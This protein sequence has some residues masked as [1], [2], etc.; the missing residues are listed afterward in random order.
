MQLLLRRVLV[1]SSFSKDK[2]HGEGSLLKKKGARVHPSS[3][4]ASEDV[5]SSAQA[6]GGLYAIFWGLGFARVFFCFSETLD[7]FEGRFC[8]T[9]PH[10]IWHIFWGH[11]V[12]GK[13]GVEKFSEFFHLHVMRSLLSRK[14]FYTPPPPSSFGKKISLRGGGEG[15]HILKP[16]AAGILASLPPHT[17]PANGHALMGASLPLW[18]QPW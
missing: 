7:F 10:C 8:H 12:F 17:A 2:V 18:S 14:K 13:L 15:V 4:D 5:T 16:S 3:R 9:D 11:I 6:E 1:R